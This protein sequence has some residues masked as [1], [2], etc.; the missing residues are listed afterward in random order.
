MTKGV[1]HGEDHNLERNQEE[2]KARNQ[3][4]KHNQ[5]RELKGTRTKN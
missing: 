5:N 2:P 3:K 4:K 1:K